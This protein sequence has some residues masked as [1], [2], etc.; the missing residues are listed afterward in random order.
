MGNIMRAVEVYDP[1]DNTVVTLSE[2]PM[3]DEID[4]VP[5]CFAT[6]GNKLY[7][8][9]IARLNAPFQD[10]RTWVFDP[11]AEAG[12][13]WSVLTTELPTPRFF[14][15][16]AVMDDKIYLMGGIAQFSQ[17]EIT[18][19]DVVSVLDTTGASPAWNDDAVAPLPEPM[20]FHAGTAV[21]EGTN[22]ARAGDVFV[23]GG[24]NWENGNVAYWYDS[25]TEK[26]DAAR[27]LQNQRLLIDNLHLVPGARGPSI[28]AESGH[29]GRI[30]SDTEIRYLG[31]DPTDCWVGIRTYPETVM[32]GCSLRLGFDLAG[33]K[34]G[35]PVDC[36]VALE[37]AGEWF[38][39]TAEPA[40]PS[41]TAEPLP[42]FA[43]APLPEDLTYCGPLFE[44][45]LP[46]DMPPLTGT[47]YAATIVSGTAELAGG[48]ASATFTVP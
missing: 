42:I 5:G 9:G 1:V 15:A 25:D 38:F 35:T 36:Y 37:T 29:F 47:F 19:Y 20:F 18:V 17:T 46:A 40:F 11:M 27:P 14:G 43:G 24:M 23:C 7:I 45:P 34:A 8:I 48:L 31:N 3:P 33:D 39:M 44:I 30:H 21:P 2:D 32:P 6:A 16:T 22:V 41:F 12:S 26:W 10:G 4:G 13:R 28:W